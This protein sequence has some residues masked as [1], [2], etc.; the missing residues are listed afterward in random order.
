[1]STNKISNT[2]AQIAL[3]FRSYIRAAG[4]RP[5]HVTYDAFVGWCAYRWTE[6]DMNEAYY[7]ITG[8]GVL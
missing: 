7:L 6:E 2:A 4:L 3:E 8:V 5:E 1:M